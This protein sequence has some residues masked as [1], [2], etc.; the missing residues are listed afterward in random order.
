MN[1]FMIVL[2]MFLALVPALAEEEW[3]TL[4]KPGAMPAVNIA[5]GSVKWSGED[6]VSFVLDIGGGHVRYD[7]NREKK[8]RTVEYGIWAFG[9]W[10]PRNPINDPWE[11]LR[12]HMMMVYDHLF[13]K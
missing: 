9:K 7:L 13:K 12:P 6:Q 5:P 1:K 4:S 8:I 2:L 10:Q 3:V 11:P